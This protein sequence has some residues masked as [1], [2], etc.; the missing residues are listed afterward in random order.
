[1]KLASKTAIVTGAARGLSF[2]HISEP[3]TLPS[4]PYTPPCAN[5]NTSLRDHHRQPYHH[6][7]LL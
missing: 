6:P 5:K 7:C 3:T 4:I 1:M 2:I